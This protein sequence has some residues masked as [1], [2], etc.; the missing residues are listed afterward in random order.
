M[1]TALAQTVRHS[2]AGIEAAG[3]DSATGVHAQHRTDAS[4]LTFVADGLVRHARAGVRNTFP[5][6]ACRALQP[7]VP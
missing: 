7:K 1:R 2:A 6:H 3:I 4:G 5:A